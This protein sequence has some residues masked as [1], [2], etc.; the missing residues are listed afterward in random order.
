MSEKATS[1]KDRFETLGHKLLGAFEAGQVP[2][3]LAPVFIRRD[4]ERQVPSERWSWS[5]RFLAALAGH[6]LA[7]GFR[8]AAGVALLDPLA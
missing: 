8:E 2:A 7:A 1:K 6:Y 5:N 3:A 4:P